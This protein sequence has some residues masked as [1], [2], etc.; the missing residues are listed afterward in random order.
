MVFMK[1]FFLLIAFAVANTHASDLIV[2][3]N[4]ED[5]TP[6]VSE[7]IPLGGYGD[8]VRRNWP[9][10][11]NQMAPHLRLFKPALGNLD[12]IRSKVM[13]L[14]KAN[15]QLLFISLDLIG[16][17][18]EMHSDLIKKLAPIGFV[19]KDVIISGT[20]THSGPG[21][22]AKNTF[23][24]AVAMD[25]FQ[26]KFYNRFLDGIVDS[27]KTAMKNSTEGELYQLSFETEKLQN[28]RRG[29]NRPLNR[30]ANLLMAKSKNGLWLGGIIHFAVHGTSLDSDNFYFSSDVPGAIER[31][32]ENLMNNE[33]GFVYA[34]DKTH[35]LFI[36]GAE[37]D[38]SPHYGYLQMG[39]EFAAQV[40]NNLSQTIMIQSD[41]ENK[42]QEINLGKSGITLS[43]CADQ[44]WIPKNFSLGIKKWISPD[45]TI[46]Q[47][48]IGDLWLLTWPGEPTTE[49]G[50]QLISLAKANGAHSAWVLGLTNDH[51][52]YFV[53]PEEYEAGGYETCMNFFGK[54]GGT[55]IINEHELLM[56]H[57]K[58]QK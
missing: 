26:K 15:K 12:P 11:F 47:I 56:T 48:R 55:K 54:N 25:R 14:K 24:A 43:K 35:F 3:L 22:L 45:S 29:N 42:E 13:Y 40:S 20:H 36:Q 17:T 49:L 38:V 6:D 19:S 2:G 44:K 23:W 1:T 18:K 30:T 58:E 31:E 57:F 7:Q 51:K 21:A 50:N 4:S 8:K 27:V 10:D 16:V 39:K 53:S 5:L 52:A 32:V 9:I 46:S 37:G 28:N 34:K 33:N 41:W